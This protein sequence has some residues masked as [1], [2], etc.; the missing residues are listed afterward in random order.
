MAIP[1]LGNVITTTPSE[2]EESTQKLTE[3]G[4]IDGDVVGIRDPEE[5]KDKEKEENE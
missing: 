3:L 4:I 5:L 2:E 1:R